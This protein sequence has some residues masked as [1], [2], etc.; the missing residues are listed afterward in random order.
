MPGRNSAIVGLVPFQSS[1]HAL[2]NAAKFQGQ[3]LNEGSSYL[4]F[5]VTVVPGER[6]TVKGEPEPLESLEGTVSVRAGPLD[7]DRELCGQLSYF[8]AQPDDIDYRPA[9]YAA[10]VVVTTQQFMELLQCASQGILPSLISLDVSGLQYG[11]EPDGSGKVW[12]S[13]VG[14][15]RHKD[16]KEVTFSF[17]LGWTPNAPRQDEDEH[18]PPVPMTVAHLSIHSRQMVGELSKVTEAVQKGTRW[19]IWTLVAVGIV[20]LF[21]K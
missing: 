15:E 20:F 10:D 7:P 2:R 6:V 19:I 9:S 13:V 21:I 12:D 16:V 8:P 14:N 3:V 17:P 5:K 11:W 18:P 4:T 1:Y